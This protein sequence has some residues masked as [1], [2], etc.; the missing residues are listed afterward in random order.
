[1]PA[2]AVHDQGFTLIVLVACCADRAGAMPP[3]QAKN[4]CVVMYALC[5]LCVHAPAW[6]CLQ[7]LTAG[8]AAGRRLACRCDHE[9]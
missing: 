5:K 4:A 1:M 9:L 8:F 6:Q 7:R 3:V 2:A